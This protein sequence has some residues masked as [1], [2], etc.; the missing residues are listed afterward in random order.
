MSDV[1]INNIKIW[2]IFLIGVARLR[3][4]PAV[5]HA[6]GMSK[7][8]SRTG[9]SHGGGV[10]RNEPRGTVADVRGSR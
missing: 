5:F 1:K 7:G 8:A 2:I 10:V 6:A 9:G 3:E 4:C